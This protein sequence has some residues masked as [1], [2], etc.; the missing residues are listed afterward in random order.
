MLDYVGLASGLQQ[1]AINTL[2]MTVCGVTRANSVARLT[3]QASSTK[4]VPL[5][6]VA[7]VQGTQ[8]YKD[9]SAMASC[10]CLIDDMI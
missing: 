3:D 6:Y 2:P 10:Q 1:D 5:C 4:K 7:G 9:A 8:D